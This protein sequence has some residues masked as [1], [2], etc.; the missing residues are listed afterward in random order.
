MDFARLKTEL[1]LQLRDPTIE[2]T[3]GA[4][5]NDVVLEMAS[6][7][8]LP[9]LRLRIPAVLT[10]TTSDW[11]YNLSA[12]V[13]PTVTYV[14]LKRTFRVTSSAFEQGYVLEPDISA[15]DDIDPDHSDTGDD[16]QRVALEGDQLAIYPKANDSLSVWF[17][18]RPIAMSADGD[19]PDGIPEPYH[20][21]V[22]IPAVILRALRLYPDDIATALPG[23]NTRALAR[24][25]AALNQGLYGDGTQIGMLH[26]IQKAQ[27]TATPRIR[28]AALGGRTSSDLFWRGGW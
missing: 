25:T 12:A 7:Y 5:L 21:K 28:G 10:T 11:L 3:F 18:R 27:R 6:M 13:H 19:T 22:L 2:S 16:V 9:A 8:E 20:F 17:Y 15:L 1:R 4:W 23:D 24:W 14:Y 26:Y